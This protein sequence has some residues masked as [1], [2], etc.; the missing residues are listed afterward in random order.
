[1]ALIFTLLSGSVTF[2]VKLLNCETGGVFDINDVATQQIDFIKPD[3]TKFSKT[4]T[5]EE[6]TAN[7]GEFF[8]QYRNIP[9]EDSI[10][11]LIGDWTYQGAGTLNNTSP[12]R[13]SEKKVFWV[14]Q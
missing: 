6:D 1:M 7:P 10:L 8:I 9:P 3:G 13:T 5:L 14:T 2:K 12:F 11:D 4:G